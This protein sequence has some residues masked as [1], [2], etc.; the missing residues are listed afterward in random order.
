M[1]VL[2]TGFGVSGVD[3]GDNIANSLR[4]RASNSAYLSRTV[5]TSAT[6]TYCLK[7]KRGKL[8]AVTPL[9]D[10]S[11]KFNA[12]DTL[13]AF[14]LT[15]TAVFRDPTK[16]YD[17][18]VSNGGLYV[19]GVSFG[20]V[21]TSAITNP[22]IGYDGT[23]YADG[24]LAMFYI[25]DGASD[26][27]TNF[28]RVSVDT[29]AWVNKTTSHTYG[30]KGSIVSFSDGTSLTTLG[31]D[32]S[33]NNNH[34][35]LNNVSLTAGVTYDWLTDTP[36]NTFATLNPLD[37]QPSK[38][39]NGNL[40]YTDSAGANDR[41]CGSFSF[42][43]ATDN[44]WWE[45]TQ[46]SGNTA[47]IGIIAADKTGIT[48][49]LTDAYTYYGVS[50]NK[51]NSG[52]ASA[53]GATFTTTDR[54][55]IHCSGGAITY[56]KQ[57]GG[58]GSFVSQG[59]AFS[60]LSGRFKAFYA[61]AGT[62]TGDFNFGQLGFANGSLPSG[63]LALN[64]ANMP[65]PAILRGDAHFQTKLDTGANIKATAEAVFPSG[66]LEEIKDRA[67]ANNW[68]YIDSVRGTSA[69]LQSNT[70]AA[71]TT[72]SAPSGSS[73]AHVWNMGTS[74]VTNTNGSISAQVRANALAGQSIVTWTGDGVDGATFGHGLG[75]TLALVDIKER[76]NTN[77]WITKHKSL[78]SNNVVFL[79]TTDAQQTPGSGY[80]GDLSSSTVVTLK[81]GGSAITNVNRNGGS[82]VAYCFA[83]V[84]GY[85]KIGSY[86]GNGSSDGPYVDCGG[87]VDYLLVKDASA[88]N[89]WRIYDAIRNQFNVANLSLY[90]N[91]SGAESTEAFFDLTATGFKLRVGSAN[92]VNDSG[93]TYIFYVVLKRATKFSNAR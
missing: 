34:W 70:T 54:I 44:V 59:V 90:P 86:A 58:S 48:T 28:G 12:D 9:V 45:V 17:I 47:H 23:N 15:T 80:I 40:R 60:G 89:T 77:N 22:R 75:T 67:N 64:T 5:T 76:G 71:E 73:V 84:P 46:T 69:V 18:H 56:Y 61:S 57:T 10:S 1:S 30:A 24:V 25:I 50:G 87:E 19:N 85:S 51:F 32:S 93:N 82:Y 52:S 27:Y 78:A 29:G 49:G 21:T 39:S 81:N 74:T 92:G 11:I 14:G 13:T 4:L 41:A 88:G 63:A 36:T 91:S 79:N 2:P 62:N 7:F 72:Y 3:I 66:F 8:G 16:F 65:M 6:A 31:Y 38:L 26:A 53:Y 42:D 33:G 37:S 20:A 35:T 55:G 83:E 43:I 68:Q